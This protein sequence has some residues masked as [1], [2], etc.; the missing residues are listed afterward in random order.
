MRNSSGVLREITY[1]GA[2]LYT[3]TEGQTYQFRNAANQLCTLTALA[4]G[5][6]KLEVPYAR[7]NEEF[8]VTWE[9]SVAKV[10]VEKQ[11]VGG[12]SGTFNFKIRASKTEDVVEYN[13]G[14]AWE[15]AIGSIWK[16]G[17]K[18]IEVQIIDPLTGLQEID[19]GTAL[20]K[21]ET[22][23]VPVYNT[24]CK[25][26]DGNDMTKDA[27][28]NLAA[29]IA[30]TTLVERVEIEGGKYLWKTD[31]KLSDLGIQ[32]AGVNDDLFVGF[33]NAPSAVVGDTLA[34]ALDVGL[35]EGPERIYFF[36]PQ[37]EVTSEKVYWNFA[38]N[39][40]QSEKP[41]PEWYPFTLA[42]GGNKEFDIP[43]RFEYEVFEEAKTGWE[44]LSIDGVSGASRASGLL[45]E[46][47]GTTPEHTFLNRE[48]PDLTV[49]KESDSEAWDTFDFTV[50]F[51]AD[52]VPAQSFTV[53]ATA[54]AAIRD[55][56][57]VT[58]YEFNNPGLAFAVNGVIV[59]A[60]DFGYGKSRDLDGVCDMLLGLS[61]SSAGS[62]ALGTQNGTVSTTASQSLSDWADAQ[63]EAGTNSVA[64]SF[65]SPAAAA[66]P[67]QLPSTPV[68]AIYDGENKQYKFRVQSGSSYTF[69]DLPYG[70]SYEVAESNLPEDWELVDR[71][72]WEGVLDSDKTAT[73]VNKKNG[74]FIPET[75]VRTDSV[76]YMLVLGFVVVCFAGFA[77]RIGRKARIDD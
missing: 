53:N 1:N 41:T 74:V 16:T 8:Q 56:V 50:K 52:A 62:I 47:N 51:T 35:S 39:K 57:T 60:G 37:R 44:L 13:T 75:G 36:H 28:N 23:T 68:G 58:T 32:F 9:R 15:D 66:G 71:H 30:G 18:D 55:G 31:K 72:G 63:T 19:P 4:D 14:T 26:P 38:T 10:T 40:S 7:S 20:P 46:E 2:P 69:S 25:D 24:D 59:P 33:L 61:A 73:F 11:T 77:F 6:F 70:L 29:L 65:D 27:I 48:L 49:S 17:T 54:T 34:T 22:V 45:T 42:N 3:M 67:C 64:Y 76:P 12:K 5:A 21:T 43:Q